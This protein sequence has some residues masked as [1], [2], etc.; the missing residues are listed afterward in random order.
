MLRIV[1]LN[2]VVVPAVAPPGRCTRRN[3]MLQLRDGLPTSLF[4]ARFGVHLS[5]CLG[6]GS[7]SDDGD[8][9]VADRA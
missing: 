1:V 8:A 4:A 6:A 3:S 7:W 5:M 9:Q 2:F